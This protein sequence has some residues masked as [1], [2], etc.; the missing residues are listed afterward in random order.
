VAIKQGNINQVF[1]VQ[2]GS[3]ASPATGSHYLAIELN[4]TGQADLIIEAIAWGYE[5]LTVGDFAIP[6][7]GH[8]FILRNRSI[9]DNFTAIPAPFDT[10]A[11]DI[12]YFNSTAEYGSNEIVFSKG[13]ELVIPAGQRALAFVAS[14]SPSSGSYTQVHSYLWVKAHYEDRGDL[15]RPVRIGR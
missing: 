8:M 3:A 4:P 6:P 15:L 1:G 13:N 9:T 7:F 5:P 11:E 12:A 10:A 14:P 2:N